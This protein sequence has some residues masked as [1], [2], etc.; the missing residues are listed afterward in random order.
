MRRNA[1]SHVLQAHLHETSMVAIGFQY[2]ANCEAIA[3]FFFASGINMELAGH[4]AF[5]KMVE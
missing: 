4:P 2:Q 5:E 1:A 3:K